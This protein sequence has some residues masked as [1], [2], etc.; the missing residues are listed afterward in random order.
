MDVYERFR[1]K[2]NSLP[3]RSGETESKVD[4]EIFKRLMSPEEAEVACYL[5]GQPEGLK[6]ISQRAGIE[7]EKLAPVLEEMARKGLI[8]KVVSAPE[9]LYCL[10]QVMPGIYEYQVGWLSREMVELFE[11]Y[12]AEGLGKAVFTPKMPPARI[13]PVNKSIP[14]ELNVLTYEE[15]DNIIDGARTICLSRCICR[16]TKEIMGEK[17]ALDAPKDDI[18][19]WFDDVGEY[20]IEYDQGRNLSRKVSKEEAKNALRRAE[21]VGLVHCATNVQEGSIVICNCCS[22]CCAILGSITRLK[23]P[24]GV[25]K[26]NFVVEKLEDK[27]TDCGECVD[28]CQVNAFELTDDSTVVLK[29]ERCIG[30]GVCVIKCPSEALT[31]K[32][33]PEQI[34]PPKDMNDLA[35]AL[36][37]AHST[38][39]SRS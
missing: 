8:F 26:S 20:F 19:F 3:I 35:V 14:A 17:C 33:R 6:T 7:V 12:Y 22:C 2:L 30:C 27:C 23:I 37:K 18:C 15:A 16:D 11:E 34:A 25:A 9:P 5:S 31:M 4:L 36:Q 10:H 1:E 21:E 39:G 32:R 29:E 24:D 38:P 28:R 13:V